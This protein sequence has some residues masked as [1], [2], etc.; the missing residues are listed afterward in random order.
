MNLFLDTEARE[1]WY[2]HAKKASWICTKQRRS[3]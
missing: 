1:A 3:I 2:S